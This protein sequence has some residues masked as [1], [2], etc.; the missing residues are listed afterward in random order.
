LGFRSP[1]S[2]EE[3][4]IE[5]PCPDLQAKWDGG[6]KRWAVQIPTA[7]FDVSKLMPYFEATARHME[8]YMPDESSK[9]EISENV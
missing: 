6:A 4:G 7:D 9:E 8:L 1:Q 3:L 2:P 5:N